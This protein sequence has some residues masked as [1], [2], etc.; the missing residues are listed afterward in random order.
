VLV[1]VLVP[2]RAPEPARV[3]AR[4]P[5]AKVPERVKVKERL[6]HS[7][8]HRRA[9][10]QAKEPARWQQLDCY[11]PRRRTRPAPMRPM[12]QQLFFSFNAP[13]KGGRCA[14]RVCIEIYGG[15]VISFVGKSIC[16]ETRLSYSHQP[17]FALSRGAVR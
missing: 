8:L 11:H 6:L 13:W 12:P 10:A 14:N 16:G 4:V 7:H 1:L 5:V 9:L 3:P 2:E 17:V 15:R